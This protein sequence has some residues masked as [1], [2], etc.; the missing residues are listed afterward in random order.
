MAV[1]LGTLLRALGYLK[2]AGIL[3]RCREAGVKSP[4][5]AVAWP[6]GMYTNLLS[7]IFAGTR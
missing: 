1:V 6:G 7:G 5:P 4:C 3:L 2:V